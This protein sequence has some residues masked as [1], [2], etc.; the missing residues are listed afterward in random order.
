MA[1]LAHAGDDDPA[2]A[3][4]DGGDGKGEACGELAPK[5]RL[6]RAQT[7][8]FELHRAG[9]RRHGRARVAFQETILPQADRHERAPPKSD[10]KWF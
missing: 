3:A 5:R 8:G 1:A 7:L 9:G 2:A 6:Q 4:A 10:R